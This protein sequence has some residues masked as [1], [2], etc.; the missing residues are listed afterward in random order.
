MYH[1][2]PCMYAHRGVSGAAEWARRWRT[3]RA[4]ARVAEA[5]G[6]PLWHWVVFSPRLQ[7]FWSVN[8]SM[9][10]SAARRAPSDARIKSRTLPPRNKHTSRRRKKWLLSTVA[11]YS[12]GRQRK[13]YAI[14]MRRAVVSRATEPDT[15]ARR[16]ASMRIGRGMG[17]TRRGG[18]S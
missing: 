14:H 4:I 10:Q 17:L 11:Q 18:S 1:V 5:T 12:P 13:K 15:S 6:W 16:C 8:S 2:P 3:C 9:A 7:F